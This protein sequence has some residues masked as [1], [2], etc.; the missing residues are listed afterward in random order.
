MDFLKAERAADR[1]GAKLIKARARC[2]HGLKFSGGASFDAG[3]ALL[4]ECGADAEMTAFRQVES[5]H[6]RSA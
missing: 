5:H 1:L 4:A 6:E 2:Y 3:L